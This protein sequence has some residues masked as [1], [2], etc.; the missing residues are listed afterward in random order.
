[1]SDPTDGS[2]EGLVAGRAAFA[3]QGD[4]MT[5]SRLQGHRE[6]PRG[7][8]RSLP[9]KRLVA[10]LAVLISVAPGQ[11]AMA[12]PGRLSIRDTGFLIDELNTYRALSRCP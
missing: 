2:K 4:R 6:H 5:H 7:V 8:T 11:V 1:L 3:N 9:I 12:A 10:L